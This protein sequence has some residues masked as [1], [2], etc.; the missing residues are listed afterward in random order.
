V[1]GLIHGIGCEVV[2]EGIETEAQLEVLR[3]IGCDILQ[4]YVIAKPMAEDAFLEWASAAPRLA[5]RA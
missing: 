3:V 5:L 1:I 4:G 2:A